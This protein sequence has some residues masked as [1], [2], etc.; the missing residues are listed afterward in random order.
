M[1]TLKLS[2]KVV[3]A[4]PAKGAVYI[5]YDSCLAGFGCRVTPNEVKSWIVEYRAHFGGGRA[6]KKRITLG[7]TSALTADAARHAAQEILARVRLGEDV[8]AE[9]AALRSAATIAELAKRYIAEEIRPTR[10]PRTAVLYEAYFRLHIIPELGTKRARDLTRAEVALLHRKIGSRTPAAANRVLTLLSGLFSWA[11]KIDE[12]PEGFTPARGITKF[13]EEGRERYL[14]AEELAR[15]GDALREAETVGIPWEV[16]E[17]R[18]TA[19]HAPKLENRRAKISPTVTAAVRLLLF[20]GCRLR[21][22]LHLRW[23]EVDFERGMLFLADSKTGRKPIVLSSAALSVLKSLPRAG[24]YVIP[25]ISPFRP[26]HD[27]QRPWAAIIKRAGLDGVRL[28][29][30]RHSFAAVGAGSGLGLPIIG[31]LL[32]HRNV[33]TTAR[34]AHLDASPLRRA[35]NLVADQLASAVGQ[36]PAQEVET[37]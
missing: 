37:G 32:G 18:P 17:A 2:K 25:G 34:Y 5:A 14:S 3:D 20:T 10:K 33:E 12:I 19:K 24:R 29:D 21:E 1:P 30:L 15:L 22:I 13:R 11:A 9:R 7:Q 6:P 16:D 35:A 31:K 4:L 23:M 28:H 26:R 8:A 27:L 36:M